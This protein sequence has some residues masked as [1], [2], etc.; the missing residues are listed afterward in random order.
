MGRFASLF[1]L[2]GAGLANHRF[3]GGGASLIVGISEKS[4]PGGPRPLGSP[5]GKVS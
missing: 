3:L 4:N 1:E 2:C 5:P